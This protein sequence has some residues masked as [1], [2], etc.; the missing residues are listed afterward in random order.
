MVV[1]SARPVVAD[2]PHEI[3]LNGRQQ[4]RMSCGKA[5]VHNGMD[6]GRDGHQNI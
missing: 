3:M 1:E 5:V 6:G 4:L 2:M